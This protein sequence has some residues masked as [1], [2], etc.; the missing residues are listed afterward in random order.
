MDLNDSA[1][2]HIAE[3]EAW[4]AAH[5]QPS[6]ARRDREI[7]LARWKAHSLRAKAHAAIW[8]AQK[9]D[10]LAR[11]DDFGRLAYPQPK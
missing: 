7:A 4:L 5:P 11:C 8:L 2:H 6:Q 9:R 1:A 10:L 3:L